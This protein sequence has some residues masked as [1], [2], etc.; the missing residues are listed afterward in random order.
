MCGKVTL[1]VELDDGTKLSVSQDFSSGDN[2]K[3]YPQQF[4]NAAISLI[5][6]ID[7]FLKESY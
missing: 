1:T 6:R 5:N 2:P 3:F 4:D 7:K